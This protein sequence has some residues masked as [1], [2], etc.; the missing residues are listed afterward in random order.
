MIATGN[1]PGTRWVYGVPDRLIILFARMN[2]LLEEFGSG[3]D[4]RVIR[5]L[6]AE[7]KEVKAIVMVSTDPSLAVG[8][9][10]VQECWRQAGYMYLYMGL[11]GADSHDA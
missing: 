1:G 10:V 2:A 3:V 5:E 8:R 7:I 9:L 11:C 6:E 4:P